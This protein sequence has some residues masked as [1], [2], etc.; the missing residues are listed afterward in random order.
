MRI[1]IDNVRIMMFQN[2][3]IHTFIINIKIVCLKMIM[4]WLESVERG[5]MVMGFE[6]IMHYGFC[7][8]VCVC[9]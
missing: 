8:C 1:C 2:E 3:I 4:V 5:K 6:V 9:A 7:C